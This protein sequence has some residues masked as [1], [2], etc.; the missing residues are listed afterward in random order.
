MLDLKYG[1]CRY[2]IVQYVAPTLLIIFCWFLMKKQKLVICSF[3][4]AAVGLAFN[5]WAFALL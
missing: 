2:V 3:S 4:N 1:K 5:I